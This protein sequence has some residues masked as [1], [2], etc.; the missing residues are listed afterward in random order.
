MTI[1]AFRVL[2]LTEKEQNYRLISHLLSQ[3]EST[4][5]ELVWEK[6]HLDRLKKIPLKE[7]VYLLDERVVG[8]DNQAENSLEEKL[9]HLI[10]S[11]SPAP[12][13]V[14]TESPQ[15]GIS[16]LQVGAADYLEKSQLSQLNLPL[17]VSLLER[18]LRLAL[19]HTQ[20][21]DYSALTTDISDR[22]QAE[23]QLRYRLVLET[24][25]ALV[26]RELASHDSADINR[27]LQLIGVA[28]NASRAYLVRFRDR[29]TL[30]SMTYEWCDSY[31]Q[32][33]LRNFQNVSISAFPWW[34]NHLRK[35][36]TILIQNL[37]EL[38]EAAQ[39]E[40]TFLQSLQVNSLLAIPI[41]NSLGQL[42]GNI[43]FDTCGRN[44]KQWLD[45]DIQ[46]LQ[47]VGSLIHIHDERI[48]AK[49]ELQASEALYAG[50]FNHSADAIFLVNV[51][52]RGQFIYETINPA[53]EEVSG[54]AVEDFVGKTPT[55]IFPPEMAAQ[56]E[57]Y[58]R[59]C[60]TIK[61][62]LYYEES[63]DLPM[64]RRIWRTSLVPIANA[65]GTIVKLQ[66]SSRDITEEQKALEEQFR[67]TRHQ[68]LLASLTL[69]IRQS[70]K[71]EEIL[72][73]A[74]TEIQK[75]LRAERVLFYQLYLDGTG[76][77]VNEE[78]VHGFPVMLDEEILDQCCLAQCRGKYRE[79]YMQVCPDVA[80]ASYHPCYR[81][82]LES[83]QIRA[84]LVLPILMTTV[85]TEI[86]S[87]PTL[88]TPRT[89][90]TPSVWGLLC[91]QQCSQARQWTNDEID[92][93][94][95]LADQLS[96]AISQAELR[97]KESAQSQDMARSN[98]EL[99]QFAYIASH[100]L[101]QPLQIIA[102]YAQLLQRL[103]SHQVDEQANKY[104]HYM[105]TEA[106][107][108]EQQI[109]DLF[110]YSRLG[111]RSKPLELIDCDEV[112][113]QAIAKLQLE[114]HQTKAIVTIKDSLPTLM[115]DDSQL[116]HLFQNLISNAI[117]YRGAEPPVIQIRSQFQEEGWLLAVEDN[118]IGIDPKHSD[119]IF[120]IFQRLHTQEEYPGSGIGLAICERIAKRHGGHIWVN[121]QLGQGSTF[122]VL[123]PS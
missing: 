82:L 53:Y 67:Y 77:V 123:L 86:D 42:W 54:I 71:I 6:M 30:A 49:Q 45:E 95:Q 34:M 62:T 99:E 65:Q 3:I 122:Y 84:N 106:Q 101:R 96:I 26:S 104:I 52:P 12:V 103:Y 80:L 100:D 40:K 23:E 68:R 63:L 60:V 72:Q 119:R 24:A 61:T 44:Y 70:W 11:V 46:L 20:V 58:Y 94:R 1:Q 51:L 88:S 118:G 112:V 28:V 15:T 33:N 76:K 120:K 73:T 81:D 98:E 110:E 21:Q 9:S 85:D 38:P 13:I 66:G 39:T 25:I 48:Q 56:V 17:S 90:P 47:V 31:T 29:G 92:L 69:K 16:A 102:G 91:V 108:M 74:V 113:Q 111:K 97:A 114:I 105:V 107:R 2:L 87:P 4:R 22:A 59:E 36:Q 18:S 83:Y 93:L 41:Y 8:M 89:P 116:I 78:V 19:A 10:T 79:D 75:T 5:F 64:G 35:N 55:E 50:I 14:L 115:A 117:K 109:Q 32:A 43:G 37:E 7:D 121:S 27:V 57:E